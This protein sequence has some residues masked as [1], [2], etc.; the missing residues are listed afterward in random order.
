[1]DDVTFSDSQVI[2]MIGWLAWAYGPVEIER[3]SNLI[4]IVRAG[5]VIGIDRDLGRALYLVQ[6]AL[7]RHEGDRKQSPALREEYNPMITEGDC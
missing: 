5:G 3:D 2:E 6:S 4:S 1:M 7:Q